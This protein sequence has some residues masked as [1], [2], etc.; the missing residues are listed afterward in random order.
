MQRHIIF[1]PLVQTTWNGLQMWEH[2]KSD[3]EHFFHLSTSSVKPR[4]TGCTIH[5]SSCLVEEDPVQNLKPL[6]AFCFFFF[7]S[8]SLALLFQGDVTSQLSQVG[9]FFNRLI[10]KSQLTFHPLIWLLSVIRWTQYFSRTMKV[11]WG[12]N[13]KRAPIQN[14]L[15][16][17]EN[18][19][20]FLF[21]LFLFSFTVSRW[22][23]RHPP[24]AREGKMLGFYRCH[25]LNRNFWTKK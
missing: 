22:W 23:S 7:V 16:Q 4:S 15:R 20:F 5:A 25:H 14:P 21:F 19:F 2:P 11:D 6:E 10:I 9:Q 3:I 17:A 8:V 1:W 18:A 13:E 12:V 24:T